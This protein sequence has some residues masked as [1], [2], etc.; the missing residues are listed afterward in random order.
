MN[1]GG[2]RPIAQSV[3]LSREVLSFTAAVEAGRRALAEGRDAS[4]GSSRGK[5]EEHRRIAE[6]L[7]LVAMGGG[8]GMLGSEGSTLPEVLQNRERLP[9]NV[10]ITYK[11]GPVLAQRPEHLTPEQLEQWEYMEDLL[12][13]SKVHY[14]KEFMEELR[15]TNK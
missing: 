4:E 12:S 2:W 7:E 9:S 1:G 13:L 15:Q 14:Y 3:V 11:D 6:Q 8:A 10:N 5:R